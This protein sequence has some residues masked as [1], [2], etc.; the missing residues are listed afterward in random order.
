MRLLHTSDWHLGLRSGPHDRTADHQAFLQWLLGT[1]DAQGVDVLVIAGDIFDQ[2]QP[3]TEAMRQWFD[4]LSNLKSTPLRQCVVIAGNHDSAARL[5]APRELLAL[6]NVIVVGQI[7]DRLGDLLVPLQDREGRI[8]AV[9]VAL[10]YAHEWRLGVRFGDDAAHMHEALVE[11]MRRLYTEAVDLAEQHYVGFPVLATGHLYAGSV[12]RGDAPHAIHGVAQSGALPPSIFDPRLRYVA[13]GHVHRSGPVGGG[14]VWYSGTPVATSV[15]E[16]RTPRRVLIVDI[17][18]DRDAVV[19]PLVVPQRRAFV[20]VRGPLEEVLRTLPTLRWSEPNPPLLQIN[21][22]VPA[23]TAG[24]VEAVQ[25]AVEHAFP[26]DARPQLVDVQCQA[27][28]DASTAAEAEPPPDVAALTPRQVFEHLL[29]SRGEV[30]DDPLLT[31]FD[32]IAA[33][34][35]G[36][37]V[38]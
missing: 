25:D 32:S 20:E 5:E 10:P 13:L 23:G 2:Y 3:T 33:G 24:V 34:V 12:Q 1:I 37:E 30:A 16:G 19:T 35:A 11:A 26:A 31:L 9:L 18:G 7:P 4:F 14:P 6:L 15:V 8:E 22:E 36:G 28:L 38:L 21:V 29:R 27:V 17:D